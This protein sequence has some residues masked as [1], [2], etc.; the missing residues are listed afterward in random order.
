MS[1]A[2]ARSVASTHQPRGSA[3]VHEPR[4]AVVAPAHELG[5][6]RPDHQ[7]VVRPLAD[8]LRRAF[9]RLLEPRSLAYPAA[10]GFVAVE[11]RQT[12]AASFRARTRKR[13][14]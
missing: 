2:V 12:V 5:A 4:R 11:V 8:H 6:V 13:M 14:A 9:D 7:E 3:T 10:T 1:F